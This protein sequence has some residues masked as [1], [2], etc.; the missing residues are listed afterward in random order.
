MGPLA[1]ADLA[2]LD[3]RWRIRKEQRHLRRA[4]VREPLIEDKRIR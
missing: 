4:G 3:V 1:T 2:G